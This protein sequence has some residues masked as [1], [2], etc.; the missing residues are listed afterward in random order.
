MNKRL[1]YLKQLIDSG[2]ADAFAYYA[3]A[4]EHKK[5]GSI[6]EAGAAFEAL[7]DK[8]PNYVPQYLMAGQMYLDAHQQSL[9][10]DWLSRG[11]VVAEKMGDSKAVGEIQAALAL[12]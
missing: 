12:C 5:E 9:A 4:M 3:L 6:A 7:R 2:K 1:T 11:L 8:F 10:A